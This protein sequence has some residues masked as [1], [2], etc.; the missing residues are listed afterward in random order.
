MGDVRLERPASAVTP[1]FYVTGTTRMMPLRYLQ[2]DV[3]AARPGAGNP[4]GAVIEGARFDPSQMQAFAAWTNLSE[5]IFLLPSTTP[6]AD[7]RVRIF[8]PRQELPFAGHPS[9]GAAWAAL[10]AGLV[11]ADKTSL[12]QECAAG[13]LPVEIQ[14]RDGMRLPHVRAPRARRI[15]GSE[16]SP[17]LLDAATR[18]M[19]GGV[20]EHA[21]WDNG[22]QW[23]LIE[24]A[25]AD[26]V[27][28][29]QPDLPAIAALTEA[30]GAVGLVV[31]APD[32]RD[33]HH[34]AVRAFCPADN[35]PEDPVTGSAQASIGAR[36]AAADRLPGH[37]GIYVGSQGRELGRDGRVTVRIN[38]E[39]MVWVG[40][41][42]QMVI[43]GELHW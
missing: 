7:Y 3:F 10:D 5:T 42:V 43:R 13:L 34:L 23:W 28:T 29:L 37:Q 27:R 8:T 18:N 25:D 26:A 9:V 30:T 16:L 41:E 19:R 14:Y 31:H 24:L 12:V 33:G 20:L 15:G 35:I 40:G 36:L 21:L 6:D 2:L 32:A 17:D 1:A 11:A 39:G 38:A 22:P 4:L